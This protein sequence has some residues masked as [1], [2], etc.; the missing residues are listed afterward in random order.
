MVPVAAPLVGVAVHVVQ[1]PGVGRVTAHLRRLPERRPRLGSVVW[2]SIEVRLLAAETLAERGGC[3]C[4]GPA[5]VLPLCLG[6]QPEFP[7]LGQ[8]AGL[9][10]EFGEFP[11][12]R[13]GLG[14]IDIADRKVIS[15]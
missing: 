10:A 3:C 6:G 1:A 5:G 2:L 11:A 14:E 9:V 15:L 13:L 8:V 7:I 12:K 4:S